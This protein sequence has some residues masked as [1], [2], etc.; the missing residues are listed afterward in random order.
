MRIGITGAAGF[1]GRALAARAAA[2]G[3]EVAGLDMNPDG[4]S[5]FQ[6]NGGR[7]ITGDIT[8][9]QHVKDLCDGVQ[10]IYHTAAIVREDGDW[11]AFERINVTAAGAVAQLAR[12]AGVRELIHFSSVMVYGFDFPEGVTEEGPLDAADNPYCW[13]KIESEKRVLQ[14]HEPG[15][16][17]TY[18]VR[19]GDVYGPGS[20]PWTLRPVEM[21][22][23]RRW[24]FVESRQA[25][26]NHVYVENL[27]DGIEVILEKKASGRPF[28]I[29]D[30][31]RTTVREFFSAYQRFLGI[32]FIPELSGAIAF[33][34]AGLVGRLA[35][36]LGID[37][38]MNRQAVRYM[39]RR[40]SYSCEAVK[41][42]GY[43]PRVTL[44]QGMEECRRWLA[45]QGHLG[46][47]A[48]AAEKARV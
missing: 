20:I 1:I 7:Y 17:D 15:I 3:H 46:K 14:F 35:G 21:M 47:A 43:R 40:H 31:A 39:L 16:F 45:G 34:V 19:P 36:A 27:L 13:S 6:S 24:I 25:I 48:V 4:K 42:L 37:A 5:F 29:T 18:I 26:F 22:K 41:A 11:K 23:S 9:P 44:A 2:A 12:E 28:A 38:G 32:R 8:N 10:R 30:D 33:P